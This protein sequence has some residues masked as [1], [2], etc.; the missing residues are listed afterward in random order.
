MMLSQL[1][2][3]KRREAVRRLSQNASRRHTSEERTLINKP[4]R[5]GTTSKEIVFGKRPFDDSANPPKKERLFG[6]TSTMPKDAQ[7]RFQA[8]TQHGPVGSVGFSD[9]SGLQ[10]TRNPALFSFAPI[11]GGGN[12]EEANAGSQTSTMFSFAPDKHKNL[13]QAATTSTEN[14]QRV[15]ITTTSPLFSTLGF[16]NKPQTTLPFSTPPINTSTTGFSYSSLP[17]TKSLKSTSSIGF[18][19]TPISTSS[20]QTSVVFES[21]FGS[22]GF[23]FA[24]ANETATLPMKPAQKF[25]VTTNVFGKAPGQVESTLSENITFPPKRSGKSPDEKTGSDISGL[26]ALVIREIPEI[27]NKNAWLKRFYSRFGEVMKVLCNPQKKSATVTFKTHEAAKLAKLKGKILRKDLNPVSIFWKQERKR[28]TSSSQDLSE[29]PVKT[30]VQER[31]K[32]FKGGAMEHHAL[33]PHSLPTAMSTGE[34]FKVLEM[35]DAKLREGVTKASDITTAKAVQGTCPDMCPEKERYMREDRRRLH[36]YETIPGTGSSLEDNPQVDHA[37]AIKEYDRSAADKEEPLPHELRPI[38]TLKMT[39]DY[40]V[41]NIMDIGKEGQWGDWFDFLWNRTRAIRKDITQQHLCDVGSVDLIEKTARFHIFCAHYLCD[42][43]LGVFD[44]RINTENLTK[45]LQTLKQFYNDLYKNEG[46]ICPNEAEFRCYDILLNLNEEDTLREVMTYRKEVRSSSM[47]KFAMDVFHALNSN[48]FVRFFRLVRASSYLCASVLHR[49]FNQAR[50]RALRIMNYSLS[51][52]N[53]E[54]SFPLNELTNLL[55]FEG[56]NQASDFCSFHGLIVNESFV[57]FTRGSFIEPESSFPSSRAHK[58]IESKR[59]CL[60]G[61]V[62]YNGPLPPPPSHYPTSSFD[63]NGRYVGEVHVVSAEMEKKENIIEQQQPVVQFKGFTETQEPRGFSQFRQVTQPVEPP[64]PAVQ[65]NVEE[66]KEVTRSLFLEVINEILVDVTGEVYRKVQ[67]LLKKAD[68]L[69]TEL[70]EEVVLELMQ[71][72]AVS[73]IA[74]ERRI[75]LMKAE[76]AAIRERSTAAVSEEL[77]DD[78]VA[79]ECLQVAAYEYSV[80]QKKVIA[81]CKEVATQEISQGLLEETLQ[82]EVERIAEDSYKEA[83]EGRKTAL[84]QIGQSIRLYR[85]ARYFHKWVKLYQSRVRLKK[86]L[87][88]FP[89]H[90]PFTSAEDQLTSLVGPLNDSRTKVLPTIRIFGDEF[91]VSECLSRRQ[92]ELEQIRTETLRPVDMPLLLANSFSTGSSVDW[93]LLLSFPGPCFPVNRSNIRTRQ[94]HVNPSL[95][96]E[97]FRKGSLPDNDRVASKVELLSL[98]SSETQNRWSVK[99][100]C[101]VCTLAYFGVP[102]NTDVT[103]LID[104]RQLQGTSAII[105]LVDSKDLQTRSGRQEARTRVQRLVRSKPTLPAIPAVVLYLESDVT[106]LTNDLIADAIG[107]QDLKREEHLSSVQTVRVESSMEAQILD[108]LLQEIVT[109]LGQQSHPVELES[110][111]LKNF[112]EEGLQRYFSTPLYEDVATRKK[113][114]LNEQSPRAI[115][116]LYNSAIEHLATV[117]SSGSLGQ[118]SWPITE[119]CINDNKVFPNFDWNSDANL[120]SLSSVILSL[121]LP[122]PPPGAGEGTWDSGSQ[123]CHEYVKSLP[124]KCCSLAQRVGWIL[125]HKHH[126]LQAIDFLSSQPQLTAAHVPWTQVIEACVSSAMTSLHSNPVLSEVEV[127]YLQSEFEEYVQ[128]RIWREAVASSKKEYSAQVEGKRLKLSF[129]VKTRNEVAHESVVMVDEELNRILNES[130][131]SSQR[132]P[133]DSLSFDESIY[134]LK[135]ELGSALREARQQVHRFDQILA[136]EWSPVDDSSNKK[137]KAEGHHE[138]ESLSTKHRSNTMDLESVRG[139]LETLRKK[140]KSERALQQQVELRLRFLLDDA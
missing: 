4:V 123:L 100:R 61:E 8:N 140:I 118:V 37:K 125:E 11:S 68:Q 57:M 114:Q 96:K 84:A 52:P 105:I 120:S 79:Q 41:T 42:Q 45:C 2:Q 47:V 46:I 87:N 121:C 44:P 88:E 83:K 71:V 70:E 19:V 63:E 50:Q 23:N 138:H 103:E 86:L 90:A 128:P 76:Q 77:L 29:L 116:D 6:Q 91:N 75:Q 81:K 34:R 12:S 21:K 129:P 110:D 132:A 58:L 15:A 113:A 85:T 56:D 64:K 92:A 107:T 99:T 39:M 112:L 65:I 80:E 26:K 5:M 51:V 97:K 54:M 74:D 40:L 66:L 67:D 1:R 17:S 127:F 3:K 35:I 36:V 38:P 135:N 16:G 95:I 139:D 13:F 59:S 134:E 133:E 124:F 25:S 104:R 109:W 89:A 20:Q 136:K 62:V 33:D 7:R 108:R 130:N 72:T 102:S 106:H 82:N 60:I 117:A 94:I 43:D 14:N 10:A 126:S 22:S 119:F 32:V 55:A 73:A 27:F 122:Q 98:Y 115:I 78:V 31:E 69:A 53:K 49:Y 28:T 18:P 93:K 24:K 30:N 101:R 137:R 9:T 48:N 131:L 111:S